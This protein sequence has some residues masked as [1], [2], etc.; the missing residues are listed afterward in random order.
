MFYGLVNTSQGL[1]ART[2]ISQWLSGTGRRIFS[3]RV[4]LLTGY[5]FHDSCRGAK[6]AFACMRY[7]FHDLCRGAKAAFACM[8]YLEPLLSKPWFC[9]SERTDES[10][11]N[12]SYGHF[13]CVRYRGNA[14]MFSVADK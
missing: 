14:W 9:L 10:A 12:V 7:L 5:L 11:M 8:R 3:R 2:G 13:A 4:H 6:T 1:L